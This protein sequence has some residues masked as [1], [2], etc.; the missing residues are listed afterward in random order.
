MVRSP[1]ILIVA[2]LLA[3]CG[4]AVGESSPGGSEPPDGA[5][6]PP[7]QDAASEEV[8]ESHPGPEVEIRL[9]EEIPRRL[10]SNTVGWNTDFSRST[11]DLDDL[12]SG[13]PPRDGIPPIDEPRFI[14]VDEAAAEVAPNE[15][16]V[17]YSHNGDHRAYP[18][19][20]L[21]W[22]EV[23]NDEVGDRPVTITFC[24]LCNTAIGFDRQV[25]D[26]LLDFGTSGL[27]RN[28]DLVM[29]DRQSE[30]LWQQATGE[31]IVG[32]LAGTRLEFLPVS[33]ISFSEFAE[34][35]PEGLVLSRETGHRRAYGANP[36]ELYDSRDRPYGFFEGEIDDRLPALERVVGLTIDDLPAAYPF[37]A[38][39]AAGVV[40]DELAGRPV[41]VFYTPDTTSA[42]DRGAIAEARAVGSAVP[43]DPVVDGERLIFRSESNRIVDEQSGSEWDIT[44]RAVSGPLEGSQ[45]E[46]LP[47]ANHFWF[48]F[49]AF[50]PNVD[51]RGSASHQ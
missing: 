11:I 2:L 47:H 24:P 48:A 34:A 30:S 5:A 41:A 12:L 17:A 18:L 16:I 44:G 36:Y 31:A 38:L 27:L 50:Y 35:F 37:S 22:H 6:P 3:A 33:I 26:R 32:E 4:A 14:S 42:L 9:N 49:Q 51:I 43:F 1:L 25:G 8:S 15:P 10:Q 45:L 13:G 23:V 28:S 21:M 40:N 7:T 20:I 29:W 19:A 39:E 46:V